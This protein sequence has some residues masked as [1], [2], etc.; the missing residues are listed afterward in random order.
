MNLRWP[1]NLRSYYFGCGNKVYDLPQPVLQYTE[2]I[3]ESQF[4]A[5]ISYLE[6]LF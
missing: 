2:V 4:G 3:F 1:A 6:E 5:T